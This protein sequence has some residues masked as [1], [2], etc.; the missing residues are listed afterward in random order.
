LAI[1]TSEHS[2][3]ASRTSPDLIRSKGPRDYC[4]GT[5]RV[6]FRVAEGTCYYLDCANPIMV[7]EDGHAIIAV[8]IPH[9]RGAN[10]GS[11]RFDPT[12]TD[13]QRAAFATIELLCTTRHKLV[14]RLEPNKYTVEMLEERKQRN[15]TNRPMASK[16]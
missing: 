4:V 16:Q 1:L 7:V 2:A 3:S 11:A 10:P 8:E 13:A 12:M 14:D 15:A 6:I 5:E 9:I